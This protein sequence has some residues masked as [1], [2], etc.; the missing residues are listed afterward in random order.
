LL[1]FDIGGFSQAPSGFVWTR[2]NISPWQ[3]SGLENDLGDEERGNFLR[4]FPAR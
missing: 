4:S 1:I 2:T 3:K